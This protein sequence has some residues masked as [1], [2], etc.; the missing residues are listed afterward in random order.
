[1]I[2]VFVFEL[3]GSRLYLD[4]MGAQNYLLGM[5]DSEDDSKYILYREKMLLE[6]FN[7]LPEF[8]GF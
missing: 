7:N 1:M 2:D 6:D 8:E 5:E 4:S 3:D